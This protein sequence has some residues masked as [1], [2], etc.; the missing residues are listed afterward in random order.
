MTAAEVL[1]KHRTQRAAEV[2]E[3]A[4]AAG[5]E[6]AAAATLLE[7]ESGGGHNVWGHDRVQTGGNYVKG[8]PVTKEAYKKYKRDRDRLGAQGVG[9]TQLT[10]PGFQ[11]RADD[12]GGCFDW[13]VNCSVGFEILAEHIKAKGIRDGFRAYNGSGEAAERYA[14][15]AMSKLAVWRSRLGGAAS[16]ILSPEEGEEEDMTGEQAR[17]LEAIFKGLTVP[18][19]NSPEETVN[20]LFQRIKNIEAA[21]NVPGTKSA[22][23]A[24]ELLFAR[25]R[26]IHKKVV[27]QQ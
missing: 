8:A 16:M 11:D 25:V 6:L 12:R 3:L 19:T 20:L 24:F 27:E 4:A 21:I 22:E 23:D 17:Q 18:G 10:F 1:E 9:P 2:V 26:E 14:D 5:L 15:D 13:R 7:K